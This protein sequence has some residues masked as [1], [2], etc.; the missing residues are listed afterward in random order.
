M[1]TC[2]DAKQYRCTEVKIFNIT[3]LEMPHISRISAL[4]VMKA[5]RVGHATCKAQVFLW[6][7]EA[8]VAVC[9]S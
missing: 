3:E 6:S 2:P 1:G 8:V 5:G 7:N 4:H 9:T